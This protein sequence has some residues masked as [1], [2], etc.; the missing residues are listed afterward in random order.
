MLATSSAGRTARWR[1]AGALRGWWRPASSSAVST[2]TCTCR[3]FRRRWRPRSP[4]PSPARA[5]IRRRWKRPD[6]HRGRHRSSTE[7]GTSSVLPQISHCERAGRQRPTTVRSNHA[8]TCPYS[9]GRTALTLAVSSGACA[10]API[11][12]E[13]TQSTETLPEELCGIPGTTTINAVDNFKLY[14]DG[15]YRDTFRFRAVSTAA[16]SGR[17]VVI[18]AAGRTTGGLRANPESR[19]NAHLHRHPQGVAREALDRRW[20]DAVAGRRRGHD[21]YYGSPSR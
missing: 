19:R 6:D 9:R 4:G 2:A 10:A 12:N 5:R 1:C 18:F 15:T 7:L 17:S 20:A 8:Q 16:E 11:L 13:H 3:P 21:R 14:A